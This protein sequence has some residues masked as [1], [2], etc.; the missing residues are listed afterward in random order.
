MN[1]L[2]RGWHFCFA[3]SQAIHGKTVADTNAQS[4]KS[5]WTDDPLRSMAEVAD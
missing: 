1:G 3:Y 2:G 4:A 5:G